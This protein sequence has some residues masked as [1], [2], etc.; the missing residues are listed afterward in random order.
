MKLIQKH[1]TTVYLMRMVPLDAKQQTTQQKREKYRIEAPNEK[2]KELISFGA[3]SFYTY[4]A[5]DKR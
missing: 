4:V 1:R 3:C 5:V 2:V